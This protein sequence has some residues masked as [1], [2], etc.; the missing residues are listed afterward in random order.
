MESKLK[1]YHGNE[2]WMSLDESARRFVCLTT[3]L[4]KHIL[5]EDIV[6]LLHFHHDDLFDIVMEIDDKLDKKRS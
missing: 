6:P 1:M 2:S 4:D 5:F 3:F